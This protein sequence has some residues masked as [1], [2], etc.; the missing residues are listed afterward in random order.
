MKKWKYSDDDPFNS[1]KKKEPYPADVAPL[2]A[3]RLIAAS[4]IV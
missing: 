2:V 4:W 3:F 1:S